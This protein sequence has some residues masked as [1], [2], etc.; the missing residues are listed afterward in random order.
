M[1]LILCL[2][3]EDVDLNQIDIESDAFNT[4]PAEMKH[5]V[6]TLLKEKKKRH[7]WN[8]ILELPQV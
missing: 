8:Q 2:L 1:S 7:T 5:E 3:Q 6:L 4:L